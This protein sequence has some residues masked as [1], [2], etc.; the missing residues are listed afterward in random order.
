MGPTKPPETTVD[1]E[2]KGDLLI[3]Y[4]WVQVTYCILDM[5]VINTDAVLCLNNKSE[6]SL[7][8]AEREKKRKCLDTFLHQRQF[9]SP[10]FVS[11]DDLLGTK[12]EAMLKRLAIRLATKWQ[13]P[14]SS[15]FGYVWSRV[16][17]K[18]VRDTNHCIRG[19]WV[20][21]IRISAQRP[22]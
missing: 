19:S 15:T 4:F 9:L 20:P 17:I 10:F 3:S 14:Y 11:V 7:V 13:Q 16:D 5:R 21:V 8:T 1:S 22:Q 12:A 6:K 18:M 2:H